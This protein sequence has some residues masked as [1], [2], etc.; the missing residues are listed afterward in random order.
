MKQLKC[1]EVDYFARV[2]CS[3]LS[4]WWML[5]VYYL[6]PFQAS[7]SKGSPSPL[8]GLFLVLLGY[9]LGFFPLFSFHVAVMAYL[10]IFIVVTFAELCAVVKTAAI[11]SIRNNLGPAGHC[12]LTQ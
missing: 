8:Q 9:L 10:L 1:D 3:V 7:L 11:D 5:V 12:C 6:P 2:F 4:L